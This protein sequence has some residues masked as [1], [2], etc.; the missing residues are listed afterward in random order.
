MATAEILTIGTELLL[1]EI[2]DTNSRYIA[3]SLRDHSVDI[4]YLGT[5]GDNAERIASSLRYCMQRSQIIITTGGLGPTIDDPTR[6]AVALAVGVETEFR[7]ELWQQVQ[8]RFAR[9]GRT[10]TENNKRQAYVPAGSIAI[11]NP[12]GTAPAFI[13]ETEENAII[14]LPGVPR[15]MEYLMQ[16]AVI[17]YLKDRFELQGMIKARILRTAGAGESAI[18]QLIADLELLTNPTVGLSAHAGSV[19]VR[20]TAKAEDEDCANE[21]IAPVEAELRQRL[22][23]WIYGADSDTLEDVALAHLETLGWNLVV[24]E[25]GLGGRLTQRLADAGHPSF[26]GGEVLGG[27]PDLETLKTA[28]QQFRQTRQADLCIGIAM[29]RGEEKQDLHLV[30]LSPLKDRATSRSYGGPPKMAV[31]WAVNMCLDLV[32][33]LEGE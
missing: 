12:V 20:I 31:Q 13:V 15:E 19:D 26:L 6:E 17:P 9:F 5:V 18:D 28:S 27:Q 21:L 2:I 3:R 7:P 25:S 33:R 30:I 16:H 24:V 8:D 22:G 10:P 11:E 4:F 32:R 23:E 1:G 29:H 14:S